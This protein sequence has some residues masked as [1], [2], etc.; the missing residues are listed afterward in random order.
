MKETKSAPKARQ[1]VY[2]LPVLHIFV[3]LGTATMNAMHWQSGW[4]YVGLIDYPISIVAV[5]LAWR[6]NWPLFPLF[7]IVGTLWWYLVSR[8]VL[9]SFDRITSF[10][11][12]A[13]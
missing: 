4:D 2:L 10:R 13:G 3:C 7:A 6:F 8:A 5:G 11:K 1:L 12:D 9:F